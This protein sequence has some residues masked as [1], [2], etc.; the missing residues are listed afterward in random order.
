MK[1]KEI[2]IN[3]S[4]IPLIKKKGDKV[5][6]TKEDAKNIGKKIKDQTDDEMEFDES[7][8]LHQPCGQCGKLYNIKH[9]STCCMCQKLICD[10]CVIM[11]DEDNNGDEKPYCPKCALTFL[12]LT[13]DE[14][15]E[16]LTQFKNL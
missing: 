2:K 4:D 15:R 16:I 3:I 8:E 14:K 13:K 9:L 11:G 7:G 6:I 10:N 1:N 12:D 5:S